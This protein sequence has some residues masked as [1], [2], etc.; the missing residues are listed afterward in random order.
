MV[1]AL[2]L[3]RSEWETHA[4]YPRQVLLLRSHQSFR[5]VSAR[6]I[7]DA[8]QGGSRNR[9]LASFSWW[10]RMMGGHEHYEESKL[11]PYLQHRWGL[12]TSH[13]T[14]GHEALSVADRAV[15]SSSDEGLVEALRDHDAILRAHLEVEEQL[16]I[17][18]L[19]ALSPDEFD[20]YANLSLRGSL[21]LTPCHGGDAGCDACRS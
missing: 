14:Q 7:A 2:D 11:Y 3:P 16:V 4:H 21:L 9:I 5:E 13:L 10:K 19:L 15:R 1:A 12:D 6:L 20:M 18:A 17:P 8:R